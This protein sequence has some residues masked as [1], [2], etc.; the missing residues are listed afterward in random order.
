MTRIVL[1]CCFGLFIA[2]SRSTSFQL[3]EAER[4]GVGFSNT[5]V[6][7]ERFNLMTYEYIYNGAGVGVGDLNNDGLPDLVFAGNQVS[8]RVYLNAGNFHFE[9]ITASFDGL[10][11]DQWFSGVAIADINGD[12]WLDVYL[13]ATAGSDTRDNRNRLWINL[14]MTDGQG[15]RFA[16][17]AEKYG[18]DSRGESV[19]AAFF[20]YDRDDDLDL[21]V[22]NSTLNQ[23]MDL[24]YRKKIT[25]GSAPN[26]DRLYRNNGDGTFSDLTLE[27]GITYEGFGLGL[28]IGDVNQDGYPDIYV[29]ND[30]TTN[31]L[32]YI[33]QGDGSFRNEIGTYLS[34]QTLSSMGN[35]MADVN[36]D[37]LPDI[38]TL[39]MLPESYA[40]KRQTINGF[41]YVY[42]IFDAQFG[43]EH[44]YLRNMLH[45]HN[46]F[47]GGEMLPYSEV[48]QM[49][50]I[51]Q[52]EWSWSPLLADFDNDG[53]RD[54][55]ITNGYP[56]DLTDKDWMR[57]RHK[58][59][60][61]ISREEQS[62]IKVMPPVKAPNIAFENTGKPGFIRTFNWLPE[63]PTYSYGAA[64]ADL[65]QDGDLDYVVNNLN[66][67][68]M[69][70]RNTA[71]ERSRG[72]LGY[73]R[74]R[75]I[76][77]GNNTQAL[78]AKVELWSQG[79][80]QYAEN[81]LTRGYASSVEP[82]IHFGL[83]GNTIIDSLKITWPAS[84][85]ISLLYNLPAN[86]L[87]EVLEDDALP[88]KART[89]TKQT[90]Y[91]FRKADHGV[92]YTHEQTDF[93]DFFL[94]QKIIPHK[95][96]QIGPVMTAGDLDGDGREDLIVGST[97]SLPTTV[98]LRRG[99]EFQHTRM[100]GLTTQKDF[101][102]AGL[103]VLDADLDGDQD[104]V[105]VAGG[106]ESL[107]E[108]GNQQELYMAVAAGFAGQNE[109][110]FQHYLYE[111][112]QGSFHQTKLPVPPFIASVVRP[113][114]FN[115]DGYPDLFIGARVSKGK[116]PHAP[117]SWLILNEKGRFS[118]KP[119]SALKLGMVTDALW[120]DVDQD[121]WEDL[122]VAREW[123]TLVLLKNVEGKE[124][125]PQELPGFNAHHG[126]WY[127]LVE[128]DLDLDGDQ[129]YVAGN[130][131]D[132][133]RFTVTAEYPLRLYALDLELDGT[134][135][136]LMTAYWKDENGKMT[137]FPVNYLDELKSQSTFFKMKFKDYASFSTTP[138][139]AMLSESMLKSLELK[140]QVNTTSSYILWNEQGSFRWEKLPEP[141]Q[142]SPIKRM[143]VRDFNGDRLPDALVAGNDYTWDVATGYYD[144]NKG[145][146]MLN[147]GNGNLDILQPAQSGL[148]LQGMVESL[149]YL[150]GDA[151]LIVA[152]INRGKAVVYELS[153]PLSPVR[154]P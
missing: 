79:T 47:I 142:V 148:L 92:P 15:P 38:L 117:D 59:P 70:L 120:T 72:K 48:G 152:G 68:A 45:L 118:T 32:L 139:E 22:M 64:F 28:A 102:E 97:N 3:M 49:A 104:V 39:D 1:L 29:S 93:V 36:N 30:Y 134:L 50:G 103:A 154:L 4:T 25:D 112:R 133:H 10:T 69:I 13:T 88:P 138:I 76:G 42:Y 121:G 96:S 125:V 71:M 151:P 14:G 143:I 127:T 116:F 2:C 35:D 60:E 141:L 89:G 147:R 84:G 41:G 9:D 119:Y 56:R 78:G 5:I 85:H 86:Q 144:A 17:M 94:N 90:N 124:L 130:L 46:G 21:Y 153:T 80:Y 149:L 106:Y 8:S 34:Y 95:F 19:A 146:V 122:L 31:D 51:F 75:L 145:I 26:N 150:E 27:A 107:K 108:S 62:V 99:Q 57:S 53:D 52:S 65:D 81:Y 20:D 63:V 100:E 105:A 140:L 136:P 23:R 91:L 44:Q 109:R 74:I 73:F 114:D 135:D 113:C 16:E 55:F 126:F 43:F 54:L 131:G 40:K 18:I 66:D 87:I 110:I 137:E 128:G 82:I 37:G 61:F 7:T 77:K 24:A 101:S 123:N 132:N 12:G 58:V 6:E 98:F 111:N 83:G 129:D 115:H 67:K 11:N 33:N